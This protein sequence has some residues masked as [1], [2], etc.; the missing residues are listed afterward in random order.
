MPL[1]NSYL[2]EW[3]LSSPEARYP[4]H[5]R[6]CDQ[7]FL[8]QVD[9][10]VPPEA[11]FGDY[12][13]FSS[14]SDSWVEHARRFAESAIRDLGLGP[15]SLVIEVA[16]NDGYLLKHFH[17]AGVSVLGIEPAANVAAVAQAAGVPTEA[18][19]F[20]SEFASELVAGGRQADLLVAN[21][22]LAHV[23]D[24]NDFVAGLTTALSPRGLLVIEVPHLLR[25]IEAL[26][27]E[28]EGA[29]SEPDRLRDEA[30]ERGE[31]VVAELVLHL[32]AAAAG[33]CADLSHLCDEADEF[34]RQGDM[35]L[36]LAT[37][38]EAVVFRRWYLG[39]VTAQLNGLPALA[40][41]DVD[42]AAVLADARLRGTVE[43]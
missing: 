10:V 35:L 31:K 24:L 18:R 42:H 11:I 38:P 27:A 12:A 3:Q 7:C 26:T 16:S 6:V 14:Y 22:V 17:N 13:Y 19:F 39:E 30:I 34:C 33:A 15:D 36:T 28:F 1:A 4:L 25:L 32:P 37:P 8:V 43:G 5:A 23:P 9:D 41:P 20:G 29:S 40:W 2:E 21:N